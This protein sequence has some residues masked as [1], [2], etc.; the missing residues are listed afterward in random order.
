MP[1]LM[2]NLFVSIIGLFLRIFAWIGWLFRRY[3]LDISLES[4]ELF[5]RQNKDR[6]KTLFIKILIKVHKN[7]KPV[8]VNLSNQGYCL[9]RNTN[10]K[11][12]I[13][14]AA[15]GIYTHRSTMEMTTSA[16][17]EIELFTEGQDFS[18]M[19]HLEA[20]DMSEKKQSIPAFF[21]EGGTIFLKV[22][23]DSGDPADEFGIN[24]VKAS[25][26][27]IAIEWDGISSDNANEFKKHLHLKSPLA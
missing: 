4:D 19:V 10:E 25:P 6:T 1:T 2:G 16:I 7:K 21:N 24:Y 3:S 18:S 23:A 27:E 20:C 8:S 11:A 17:S 14:F 26:L 12:N 9:S 13:K 22:I 5:I 15:R